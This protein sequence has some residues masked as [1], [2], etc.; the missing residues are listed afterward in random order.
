MKN[1]IKNSFNE[2]YTS[3]IDKILQTFASIT[4][5]V[6]TNTQIYCV[7]IGTLSWKYG[8][9]YLEIVKVSDCEDVTTIFK[10]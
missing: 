4:L 2:F 1:L 6:V 5:N 3:L 7:K 10:Q 9:K 8:N